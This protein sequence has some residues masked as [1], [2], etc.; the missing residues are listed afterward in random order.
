VAGV[1]EKVSDRQFDNGPGLLQ[2][3]RWPGRVATE[4][5][6]LL[7]LPSPR[8][9]RRQEVRRHPAPRAAG[10]V[11]SVATVGEGATWVAMAVAHLLA[12]PSPRRVSLT[13]FDHRFFLLGK[14][15]CL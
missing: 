3:G 4:V 1:R 6:R 13:L 5:A 9:C 11:A 8:L 15:P 2:R 10:T 7:A 12:L 14:T